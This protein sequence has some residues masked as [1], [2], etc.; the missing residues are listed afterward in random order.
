MK[1]PFLKDLVN[2]VVGLAPSVIRPMYSVRNDAIKDP[3]PADFPQ[4]L[5][6]VRTEVKLYQQ[7]VVREGASKVEME[8]HRKNTI[9][10]MCRMLY[11]PIEAELHELSR[12]LWE[13]GVPGDDP[14]M[15][16][17]TDLIEACRGRVEQ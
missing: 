17:I 15:K 10:A 1:L 11:G 16:R 14:A 13:I 8:H 3:L 4:R 5:L 9:R 2:S 7:Y 6:K 12:E